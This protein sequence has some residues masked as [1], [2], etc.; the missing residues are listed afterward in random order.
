VRATKHSQFDL[1]MA[2]WKRLLRAN[3]E[4]GKQV[5]RNVLTD[6]L[7]SDGETFRGVAT[8]GRILAGTWNQVAS[9]T[10]KSNVYKPLRGRM[11]RA[12]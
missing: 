1:I 5:L 9:P 2:N 8:L 3:R 7:I 10:G 11:R 6:R 12:A 4:Q